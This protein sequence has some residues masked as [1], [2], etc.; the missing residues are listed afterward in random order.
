MSVTAGLAMGKIPPD[1]WTL[2]EKN[3]FKKMVNFHYDLAPYMYDSAMKS[4]SSGYPYTLTP[5]SIAY[6]YDKQT[7]KLEH[8]QWM[9][10]E[11]VM[12]APLVKNYKSGM[13]DVYLPAGTWFDYDSGQKFI[14]PVMLK[15]FKMPL[16]KTPCFIGGKGVVVLRDSDD[17]P[18]KVKIYPIVK[19]QKEFTFNYPDGFSQSII[20][21]KALDNKTTVIDLTTGN[22]IP[23]EVDAVT[24]SISFAIKP[25]H[26]YKLK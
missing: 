8:Y 15:G 23:F 24:D 7:S 21:L 12:A 19:D 6:P 18:L 10:G 2:E 20:E 26:N 1:T 13:L 9:I 11:S 16:D 17:S 25:G 14:G 5:L 3:M 4:Y 22:I